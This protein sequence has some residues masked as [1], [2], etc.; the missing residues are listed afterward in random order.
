[1]RYLVD[2]QERHI[3]LEKGSTTFQGFLSESE[4]VLLRSTID[5][6][7]IKTYQAGRNMWKRFAPFRNLALS[8]QKASIISGLTGTSPITLAFDQLC[9]PGSH[10]LIP[11]STL[12]TYSSIQWM[13]GCMIYDLTTGDLTVYSP[14]AALPLDTLF[15]SPHL[16]IA[17]ATTRPLYRQTPTDPHTHD[18]KKEGY[19]Y[20]DHLSLA[21]HPQINTL[22]T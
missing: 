10:P 5:S 19:A 4:L 14:V 21:T 2:P 16:L 3:Y 22:S 9:L 7:Q 13:L 11:G 1:M 8:R 12:D 6:A 20:G 15:A 17:Y 18:L